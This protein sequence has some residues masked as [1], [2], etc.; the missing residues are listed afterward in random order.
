MATSRIFRSK[1][2]I[3]VI[4]V[5]KDSPCSCDHFHTKLFV[6]GWHLRRRNPK[7]HPKKRNQCH[8]FCGVINDVSLMSH[9]SS[10]SP[11]SEVLQFR[12]TKCA[13]IRLTWLMTPQNKWHWLR[14]FGCFLGFRLR[15]CQPTTKRLV[16]KWSQEWGG[17]F[18]CQLKSANFRPKELS[19]SPLSSL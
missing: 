4:Y 10:E 1:I 3:F 12:Q 5:S 15:K 16:W 14:F 6:V 11:W 2:N 13:L 7:K 9:I 19:K 18:K 8:L 17:S